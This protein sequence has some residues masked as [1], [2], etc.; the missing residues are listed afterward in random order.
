MNSIKNKTMDIGTTLQFAEVTWRML[1]ITTITLS[2]KQNILNFLYSRYTL[3]YKNIYL[4]M[5]SYFI[6]VKQFLRT[7]LA[8]KDNN[9]YS[10]H[11]VHIIL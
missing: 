1:Q 9:Q 6:F 7:I 8:F 10:A 5:S 3:Y 4:S 11:I 2:S